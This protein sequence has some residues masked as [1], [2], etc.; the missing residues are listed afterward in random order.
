MT[1]SP[2]TDDEIQRA[3]LLR[4]GQAPL[5]PT[6]LA[7]ADDDEWDDDTHA[8]FGTQ[9]GA[10]GSP[11]ETGQAGPGDIL[12][13]APSP[14][15]PVAT[16][17]VQ[18]PLAAMPPP[19]DE[20]GATG[21][22][23]PVGT[24]I[25]TEKYQQA[26]A[27]M[28]RLKDRPAGN[29]GPGGM[30]AYVPVMP[31]IPGTPGSEGLDV[32]APMQVNAPAASKT[33]APTAAPA[34]TP[35]AQDSIGKPALDALDVAQTQEYT[36]RRQTWL[37]KYASSS[38]T[39][40]PQVS[41]AARNDLAMLKAG[42]LA[43][44]AEYVKSFVP[45]DRLNQAAADKIVKQDEDFKSFS[46]GVGTISGA[47][48]RDEF[49]AALIAHP[50]AA[51][52]K[53]MGPI[54]AM[55]RQRFGIE[56]RGTITKDVAGMNIQSREKI[57]SNRVKAQKDMQ[58]RDIE[59]AINL[60]SHK[61]GV[62]SFEDAIGRVYRYS[63]ARL[64]NSAQNLEAWRRGRS[65]LIR[66][67]TALVKNGDLKK[68]EADARVAEYDAT[69]PAQLDPREAIADGMAKWGAMP[70]S[71]FGNALGNVAE[72]VGGYFK[73]LVGGVATEPTAVQPTP[74]MPAPVTRDWRYGPSGGYGAPFADT[75]A[76]PAEEVFPAPVIPPPRTTAAAPATSAAAPA[77]PTASGTVMLKGGSTMSAARF[78][79]I[80]AAAA[81]N[82]P[83]PKAVAWLQ[84]WA[85]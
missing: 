14:R 81:A 41:R 42:H 28:L 79:R 68:E 72:A 84:K 85:Q 13:I 62:K 45:Q 18:A 47:K 36:A 69:E 73:Q 53:Q 8:F 76:E 17:A 77:T 46:E 37:D 75:G 48:T 15:V 29:Y 7:V 5:T 65:E 58:D 80:K 33:V 38:K 12:P 39:F 9:R 70:Q 6:G 31:A 32:I 44:K 61:E 54:L 24:E 10:P 30:G 50:A 35:A 4:R 59:A 57:A 27:D 16:P 51:M 2:L 63:E 71:M 66:S 78:G 60:T 52:S 55:Q 43:K 64:T 20:T 40:K 3:M 22:L 21:R 82:P 67:N 83:D 19:V 56:E 26:E 74:A 11:G 1:L 23:G 25:P 34:A 49:T